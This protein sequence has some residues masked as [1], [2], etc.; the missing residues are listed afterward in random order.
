MGIQSDSLSTASSAR[1]EGLAWVA[2]V[3]AAVAMAV[4]HEGATTAT[5]SG[6]VAKASAVGT[7]MEDGPAAMAA[8]DVAEATKTTAT[9]EE[10]AAVLALQ[11]ANKRGC[12]VCDVWQVS[13]HL[14]FLFLV[15]PSPVIALGRAS[16]A[17]NV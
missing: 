11:E 2:M 10:R 9:G 1:R 17:D 14:T 12:D 6:A 8:E 5:Y 13:C 4:P 16:V 7:A 3:T 15:L